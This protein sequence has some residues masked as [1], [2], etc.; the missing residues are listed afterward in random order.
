M[1]I[2]KDISLQDITEQDIKQYVEERGFTVDILTPKEIED[3]RR[4]VL[5]IKQ[6]YFILDGVLS[7]TE[8]LTRMWLKEDNS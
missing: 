6:G 4:E 8:L 3:V 7:N 2:R 5:V 1:S